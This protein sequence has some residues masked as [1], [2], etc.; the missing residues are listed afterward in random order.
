MTAGVT[1]EQMAMYPYYSAHFFGGRVDEF[2]RLVRT[3]RNNTDIDSSKGLVPHVHDESYLNWYFVQVE[4]MPTVELGRL[5]KWMQTE[6]ECHSKLG[7]MGYAI[8]AG[9]VGPYCKPKQQIG[10]GTLQPLVVERM[11][12]KDTA[13][14]E[15]VTKQ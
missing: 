14:K 7:S 5:F 3:L 9:L 8:D 10:D 15:G 4:N 12:P 13:R 1:E 2:A 6:K 11:M